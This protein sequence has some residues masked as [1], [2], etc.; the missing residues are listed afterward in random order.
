MD[1][2]LRWNKAQESRVCAVEMGYLRGACV[3]TRGRARTI[4]VCMKDETWK[5]VQVWSGGKDEKI[6]WGSFVILKG[7]R[8]KTL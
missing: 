4:E 1:Q 5:I 6:H 2:R 3:V 8:V 7:R